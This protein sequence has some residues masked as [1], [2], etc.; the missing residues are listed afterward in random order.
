M[1][2]KNGLRPAEIARRT[3]V[4]DS[5][6]RRILSFKTSQRARVG[7]AGRPPKLNNRNV[8]QLLR[9]IR[10]SEKG[11]QA[12]YE[13]LAKSLGIEASR[14]AIRRALN[15]AGYFKCKA[16][17]KPYIN[18]INRRKRL[19]FAHAHRHW[20][21]DNWRRVIWTDE[22]SFETGMRGQIWVTRK[23]DERFC[24]DCTIKTKASGRTSVMVW[25][26]IW[27]GGATDLV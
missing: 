13:S 21:I 15:E 11:R 4:P 26:G 9:E 2:S 22:S 6:V 10:G 19:E 7:R 27:H 3:G 20:G 17:H 5:S 12:P 18:E 1:S 24:P 14:A 23:K 16:C 25:G 8:R